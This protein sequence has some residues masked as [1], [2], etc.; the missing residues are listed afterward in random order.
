MVAESG[1]I[2]YVISIAERLKSAREAADLRQEELAS[3]AGVSQGTIANVESGLRK[4]PRELLAIARA[5]NVNAEWLK[6]GKGPRDATPAGSAT[7]LMDNAAPYHHGRR[8]RPG[9]AHLV[10]E[11]GTHLAGVDETRRFAIA[12]MLSAVAKRP[13]QAADVGQHIDALLNSKPKRAA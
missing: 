7:V 4:N 11:I 2:T 1:P 12:E 8:A 9:I 5:L 3:R 13:E 6:S 10:A